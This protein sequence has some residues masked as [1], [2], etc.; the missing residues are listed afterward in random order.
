MNS[1]NFSVDFYGNQLDQD[2]VVQVR[3]LGTRKFK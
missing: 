3:S 2:G 1:D